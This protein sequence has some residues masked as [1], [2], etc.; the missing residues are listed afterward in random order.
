MATRGAALAVVV[1]GAGLF[2][3]QGGSGVGA[4]IAPTR[5]DTIHATHS[6]MTFA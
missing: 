6:A 4:M 5:K 1:V 2:K 3:A